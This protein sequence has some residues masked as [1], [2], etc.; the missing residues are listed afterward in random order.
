[1]RHATKQTAAENR[2]IAPERREYVQTH[3]CVL[4]GYSASEVHEIEGGCY[5]Q[6]T[7]KDKRYWLA[8][9]RL[10][11]D[12]LQYLSKPRQWMLKCMHDPENFEVS[13]MGELPGRVTTAAEVLEEFRKFYLEE[14]G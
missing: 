1:M 5:R 3:R 10:E 6:R 12:K 4:S 14:M 8:V 2:K 7:K 13:A 11:H 9:S